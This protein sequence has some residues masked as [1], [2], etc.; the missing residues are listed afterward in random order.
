MKILKIKR[1]GRIIAR[2][3]DGYT[4][5]KPS[6]RKFAKRFASRATR[7]AAV[8]DTAREVFTKD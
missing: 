4:L 7:R 3:A 1:S 5:R 6:A 8:R 2:L